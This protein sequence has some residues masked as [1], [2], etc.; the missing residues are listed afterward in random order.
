MKSIHVFAKLLNN[1]I[2]PSNSHLFILIGNKSYC[3]F[4]GTKMKSFSKRST[5]FVQF[6]TLAC[7]FSAGLKRKQY[8]VKLRIIKHSFRPMSTFYQISFVKVNILP[9]HSLTK[10][11]LSILFYKFS[12]QTE[13]F[14][15][16]G[17]KTPTFF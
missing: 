15:M 3:S 9:K 14:E 13:K 12:N 8:C 10:V 7:F 17:E 4:M 16:K 6:F 2:R 5:F 11:Q 1:I